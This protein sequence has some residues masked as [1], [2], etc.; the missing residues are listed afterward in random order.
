[1]ASKLN[2][3]NVM[4]LVQDDN[5]DWELSEDELVDAEN[6]GEIDST[7]TTNPLQAYQKQLKSGKAILSRW[8]YCKRL[9]RQTTSDSQCNTSSCMI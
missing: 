5:S 7:S 1:M 6:E 8:Q 9:Y 4:K 2:L 3:S